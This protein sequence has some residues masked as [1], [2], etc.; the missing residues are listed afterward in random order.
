MKPKYCDLLPI[1]DILS[2]KS[3]LCIQPHPDDMEIGAGA[4]LARLSKAGANIIYLT[5]TDGSVGTY[6]PNIETENLVKTR[7][8]ETE[9][10]GSLVGVKDFLWLD[11]P[12]GGT[13]PLEEVRSDITHIIRKYR[14]EAVMV[15]DPWLPYEA[16][17]DHTKTGL[18]AAEA[19]LLSGMPNF[20][21]ADLQE[22]LKPYS[23][24]MVAFYYTAYPNTFID[25]S[26][27]WDI[28]LEAIDC[29]KSQFSGVKADKLKSLL[30]AR[31]ESWSDDQD[32]LYVEALKVL[33]IEHLHIIEDTWHC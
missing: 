11:Y 33:S 25:V 17:S 24:D 21:P 7:R 29:H 8:G 20:C 13:L 30:T 4:T 12:D 6:D 1:P 18:A 3:F 32:T 27:S 2:A 26:Q 28:K 5:I 19:C 16:H 9:K 23:P 14:P 15:C 22:G 10:S 31:A